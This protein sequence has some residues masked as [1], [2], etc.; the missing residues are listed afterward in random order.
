[1]L[2]PIKDMN[3]CKYIPH[4]IAERDLALVNAQ[5]LFFEG[6]AMK[7]AEQVNDTL[8]AYYSWLAHQFEE[9]RAFAPPCR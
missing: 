7:N 6:Y 4:F 3:L 5:V 1:M 9:R 8:D 2:A